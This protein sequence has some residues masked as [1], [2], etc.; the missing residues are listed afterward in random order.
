MTLWVDRERRFL[1]RPSTPETP[2]I[3]PVVAFA[4]VTDEAT[5]PLALL[6]AIEER[7]F[8]ELELDVWER[9]VYYRLLLQT[10]VATEPA[11][12]GLA[13][14][15]RLTGMSEDKLRRTIRSMA[16]KGCIRIT[17]R[18]R[19]GHV[20]H[21]LL[22]GD[23]ESLRAAL[24]D[25]PLDIERIDFFEDRRYSRAIL[26]RDG[27][28]CFYCG[29]ALTPD[30]VVLDHVVASV[31]GGDNSHRN[32]VSACHECN[33]AKQSEPAEDYLRRLYR[34]GVLSQADL[35]ERLER[36]AR[37]QRG[38]LVLSLADLASPDSRLGAGA[39]D[40]DD[41]TTT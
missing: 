35:G 1:E 13:S 20:V 34:R 5:V 26:V 32:I 2:K 14:G 9:C 22:P 28:A 19:T 3:G 6:A 37:L 17:D 16:A 7:L 33:S 24:V 8:Q 30:N 23:V 40:T 27:H 39:G 4:L 41:G 11:I 31:T 29:R 21:L 18:G 12:I 25:Q 10:Q 38:E 15:S 36:L